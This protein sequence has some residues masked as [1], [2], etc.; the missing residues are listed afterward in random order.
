LKRELLSNHIKLPDPFEYP[1]NIN[2][3]ALSSTVVRSVLTMMTIIINS[4][5]GC[6]TRFVVQDRINNSPARSTVVI[7]LRISDYRF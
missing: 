5:H 4:G 7:N 1:L 2:T 6:K 3:V